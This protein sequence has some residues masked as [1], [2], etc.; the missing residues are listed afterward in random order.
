MEKRTRSPNYPA[1]GLREAVDRIGMLYKANQTHPAPRDVIA[2]GLGY[3]SLNGASATA[4]SALNKY[5]LLEGRGE[6]LRVSER[7]MHILFP[8]S[9]EEKINALHLA[10]DEPKLFTE[11]AERFP[12][13]VQNDELLKNYLLRNGFAPSAVTQAIQAYR[14]TSEFVAQ[15]TSGYD[16][17]SQP[18]KEGTQMVT[19]PALVS[20]AKFPSAT[21]ALHSAQHAEE[22]RILHRFEFPDGGFVEIKVSRDVDAELALQLIETS[23]PTVKAITAIA[24]KARKTAPVKPDKNDQ[25]SDEKQDD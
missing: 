9:K 13:G 12:G 22:D 5:G 19:P 18:K 2:K 3:N 1:F 21:V 25:R 8:Q 15:E 24:E 23:L 17:P 4:I 14:E 20:E 11:L 10:A 16:S 6:D 7:A